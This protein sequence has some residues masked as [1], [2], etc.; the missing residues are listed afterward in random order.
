MTYT[1]NIADLA[2]G[3]N[4]SGVLAPT[5]GGTGLVTLTAANNALYSTSASALTAGTLPV[6][7]GGTGTSTAF[8]PGSVVFAGSSS[9][10]TQANSQLFW[11]S[12]NSYLGVGTNTPYSPLDVQKPDTSTTIGASAS[13]IRVSNGS[14]TLNGTSGVEFFHAVN[15]SNN[16]NR[17]A[18]VY[19]VY[20]SYNASGLGGALV[21]ATNAAGN[22]TITERLRIES[23]GNTVITGNCLPATTNTV[24]LGSATQRWRNVYTQDLH[25]S[26]GVGDWTVVEGEQNLYITNN[27]SGKSYR[28]A[29]V[30]VDPAEVPPKSGD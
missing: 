22:S 19:G 1:R 15:T 30:E 21:F 25:L 2:P 4:T 23:G 27:K 18:G 7:A 9:V 16:I 11:D 28:F 29:L 5:N 8:T 14:G 3:A 13:V 26:N 20:S 10:Y 24:D 17:L 12:T 6:A